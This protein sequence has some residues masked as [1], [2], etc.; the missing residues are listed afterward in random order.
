MKAKEMG[1]EI[2]N[3]PRAI[4][5]SYDLSAPLQQGFFLTGRPKQWF[6]A[7]GNMFK[8]LGSEK[9]T[10]AINDSI[11]QHPD[12]EL[13]EKYKLSLPERE[14]VFS[15]PLA[16]RMFNI[17]GFGIGGGVRVSARA[18]NAFLN[19]LRFDVFKSMINKAERLG[20][21]PQENV[22]L[23][24]KIANYI[25]DATGRG[26]LP[27]SLERSADVINAAFFAPRLQASTLHLLTKVLQPSFYKKSNSFIR[28]EYFRDLFSSTGVMLSMLGLAKLAGADVEGD[29]RSADFGKAKFGNTRIAFGSRFLP[30][31]RLAAQ[32]MTN[33]TMDVRGHVRTLGKG[34][35]PTT[36]LDVV[37]RFVATKVAPITSFV[38]DLLRGVTPV[39]EKFNLS[40]AIVRR[41][42]PMITQDI[43]DIVKDD[44]TLL[45]L[46]I[47]GMFG[48][49]L[50]TYKSKVGTPHRGIPSVL[51]P[52]SSRTPSV[53]PD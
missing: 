48:A 31:I 36:R 33:Q 1:L 7:F 28:K 29:P 34:F 21:K 24:E 52:S 40:K 5:T 39:G 8:A 43:Y 26:R 4:M 32:L 53:L 16:E 20:H 47:P 38:M 11:R 51:P 22:V 12:Y 18:Y 19:K 45:P 44:P 6:P 3:I 30:Y 42:T 17:K 35:K 13:A 10:K 15:S 37:G 2:A 9:A 27:G 49:G 25:N 46:A 41:M 23:G 14:E 50:Q